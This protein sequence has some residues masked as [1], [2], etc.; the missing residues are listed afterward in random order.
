MEFEKSSSDLKKYLYRKDCFV[1]IK[2]MVKKWSAKVTEESDPVDLKEGIFKSKDPKEIALAVKKSA[3]KG[4]H[5]EDEDYRSAMSM[6]NF[7]INR[8][9][10]N[11]TRER[12]GVLERAKDELKKLFGRENK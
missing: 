5:D 7:Y 9:G 4:K 2:A 6:L 11:L 12:L 1:I 3:Q 8:A 10:D